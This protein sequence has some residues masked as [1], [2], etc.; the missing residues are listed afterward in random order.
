MDNSHQ[1]FKRLRTSAPLPTEGSPATLLYHDFAVPDMDPR[2][3]FLAVGHL[4]NGCLFVNQRSGSRA[5]SKRP[6]LL[7]RWQAYK[8]LERRCKAGLNER[9]EL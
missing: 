1:A 6:G 5:I 7:A 8:D 4:E 3:T 2:T 9:E